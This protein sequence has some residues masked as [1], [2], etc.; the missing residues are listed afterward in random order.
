MIS[1]SKPARRLGRA[2]R[3]VERSQSDGLIWGTRPPVRRPFSESICEDSYQHAQQ[4]GLPVVNDHSRLA[5]TLFNKKSLIFNNLLTFI[6]VCQLMG[7]EKIDEIDKNDFSLLKKCDSCS[8]LKSLS[9]NG[10]E[11]SFMRL[12]WYSYKFNTK[13]LASFYKLIHLN[14]CLTL[15]LA[16]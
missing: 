14:F 12:I 2:I 7:K 11:V 9:V 8:S 13:K 15:P 10:R 4:Q 3:R 5:P 6:E 1:L 16:A